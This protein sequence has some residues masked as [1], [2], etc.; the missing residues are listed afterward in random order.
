LLI[1]LV[2]TVSA[3]LSLWSAERESA[4]YDELAYL[5][6]GYAHLALG[7]F[8]L[9]ISHP[10]LMRLLSATGMHSLRPSLP[11]GDPSWAAA[12]FWKFGYAFLYAEGDGRELLFRARLPM[13]LLAAAL[14]IAVFLWSRELWG[15]T[16]A[17]TALLLYAFHPEVLAHSHYATTDFGFA[18]FVTLFLWGWWRF[19]DRPSVAHGTW[20]ALS[21]ALAA[22]TKNSFVVLLP[23]G[24]SLAAGK[25]L[26]SRSQN[27]LSA[28][29]LAIPVSC[30]LLGSVLTTFAAIWAVYGFEWRAYSGLAV[31]PVESV[32]NLLPQTAVLHDALV[33]LRDARL[34]PEAYVSSLAH[35]AYI[36]SQEPRWVFLAGEKSLAGWWYYYPAVLALK[37]PLPLLF[38][39]GLAVWFSARRAKCG[40]NLF[41]I[42][43][44]W[45]VYLA[46][47][48]LSIYNLG[49]RHLLPILP[50]SCILASRAVSFLP[51]LKGGRILT[52]ALAVW[53]IGGTARVAP[54]FLSYFNELAGGPKQGYR[55][56]V[57]SNC[58]WGQDLDELARLCRRKGIRHIKLSYFG[59]ASPDAAGLSYAALPNVSSTWVPTTWA[60]TVRSGD[61]LAVSTTN[62]M[63]VYFPDPDQFHIRV[64]LPGKEGI[65]QF[66][67]LLKFVQGR[68]RPA[69]RAGYSILVYHLSPEFEL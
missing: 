57:D 54:H 19:L 23:M 58:D 45:V 1:T 24:L 14:G 35:T 20:V 43:V 12:D 67:E 36:A 42:L 9:N 56:L 64:E 7:D 31:E 50:L 22:T 29:R 68:Y 25:L 21:I 60:Q 51:E 55:Y 52:A 61:W 38:L 17:G 27:L 30:L 10:P 6:P 48:M 18:A 8:R 41:L 47:A 49:A 16:A 15:S 65:V 46:F 3:C 4:T 69:N 34:L 63:Q 59:T 40:Q 53:Y 66:A 11:T 39:F 13:V 32:E 62:L 5:G 33:A 26:V 37:S 28:R 44:P 2:L